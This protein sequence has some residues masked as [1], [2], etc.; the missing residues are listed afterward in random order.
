M[1]TSICNSHFQKFLARVDLLDENKVVRAE[2]H[3]HGFSSTPRYRHRSS[4][5]NNGR[6]FMP[7]SA[8]FWQP[9]RR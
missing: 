6:E 4:R 9:F 2:I 1:Y 3:K 8:M 5:R 7:D